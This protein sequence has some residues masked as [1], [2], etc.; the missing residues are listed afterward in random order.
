MYQLIQIVPANTKLDQPIPNFTIEP[1]CTNLYKKESY[2]TTA[3][4]C[5]NLRLFVPTSTS[6]DGGQPKKYQGLKPYFAILDKE[7][8]FLGLKKGFMNTLSVFMNSK[9]D[10]RE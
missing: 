1:N 5:T 8:G 6:S 7:W 9:I 4:N 3:L 10:L 2:F